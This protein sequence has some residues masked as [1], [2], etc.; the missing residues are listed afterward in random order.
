MSSTAPGVTEAQGPPAAEKVAIILVDSVILNMSSYSLQLYM[1]K[2]GSSNCEKEKYAGHYILLIGY[3]SF[4]QAFM[5]LDPAKP[6]GKAAQNPQA[7]CYV[8]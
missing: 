8:V 1:G 4:R 2:S 6:A 5:H 7:V 3:N